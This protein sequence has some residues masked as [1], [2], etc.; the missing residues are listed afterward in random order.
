MH[1]IHLQTIKKPRSILLLLLQKK[2]KEQRFMRTEG[3]RKIALFAFAFYCGH[4]HLPP[5][6]LKVHGCNLKKE[7]GEVYFDTNRASKY[8]PRGAVLKF[9]FTHI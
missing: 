7:V 4:L 8:I 2:K 9:H 6:R 5:L 3:R 1:D